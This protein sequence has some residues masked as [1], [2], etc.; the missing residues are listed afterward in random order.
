MDKTDKKV[1]LPRFERN[2]TTFPRL[3]LQKNQITKQNTSLNLKEHRSSIFLKDEDNFA[4][5][6]ALEIGTSYS[7]YAYCARKDNK[8]ITKDIVM[9]PTWLHTN[10]QLTSLRTPSCLLL[11]DKKEFEAYGYE[12][13]KMFSDSLK[14]G[15]QNKYFYFRRFKQKLSGIKD[16]RGNALITDENGKAFSGMKVFTLALR[17][18]KSQLLNELCLRG[19]DADSG[20]V[21]WIVTV[22]AYWAD[23]SKQFVRRAAVLAGIPDDML[24]LVL[25]PEAASLFCQNMPSNMFSDKMPFLKSGSKYVLADIGGGMTD[26]VMHEKKRDGLRELS[27]GVGAKLGGGSVDNIFVQFLKK[28][29]G[30]FIT[31]EFVNKYRKDFVAMMREF[32]LQKRHVT[33]KTT[34]CI[35]LKVPACLQLL[36]HKQQYNDNLANVIYRSVYQGRVKLVGNRMRIDAVI[37]N[38]FFRATT[39][40]MAKMINLSLTSQQTAKDISVLVLTGGF[41][42]SEAVQ[43]IMHQELVGN[44]QIKQI[45]VPPDAD[46]AV[47]KGAVIFGHNPGSFLCRVNRYTLGLRIARLYNPEMHSVDR[48]TVLNGIEYVLDIFSPF[49][50]I[51]T[52]VPVGFVSHQS[53]TSTEAN[54]RKIDIDIYQSANLSHNFVTDEGCE[55]LGKVTYEIPM[56]SEEARTIY[57]DFIL[58]DTELVMWVTDKKTTFKTKYT[59]PQLRE[60]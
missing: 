45:V 53:L 18:L 50:T 37:S 41:A 48:R 1:Y 59:F 44:S 12:A 29:L 32:E 60:K 39:V 16:L 46:I 15:N 3:E 4:F 30:D 47:L 7:G 40:E 14:E 57:V 8:N 31:E 49:L 22:P 11:N 43:E 55:H 19:H 17:Y 51:G 21:R 20:D 34:A 6:A 10:Q 52:R 24:K 58:G 23:T 9:N 42:E 13:E 54:Q 56:P 25:E 26:V 27:R 5:V 28:M 2:K 33:P 38:E 35:E 36:C